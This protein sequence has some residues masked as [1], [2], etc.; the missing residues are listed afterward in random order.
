MNIKNFENH[1]N[2]T[3]VNRGYDYYANG[4]LLMFMKKE[5]KGIA[6]QLKEVK[7]MK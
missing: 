6:S 5:I 3:I 7:I 2:N 1:I 4:K